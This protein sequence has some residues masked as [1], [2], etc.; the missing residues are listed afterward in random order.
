MVYTMLYPLFTFRLLWYD[1]PYGLYYH[2]ETTHTVAVGV[3][4]ISNTPLKRIFYLCDFAFGSLFSM[5][6]I[7]S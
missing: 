5:W 6:R 3:L 7:N 1:C 2:T 4:A